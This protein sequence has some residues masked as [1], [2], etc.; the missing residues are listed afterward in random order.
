MR[1][2][3]KISSLNDIAP[4]FGLEIEKRLT[5]RVIKIKPMKRLAGNV[6]AQEQANLQIKEDNNKYASLS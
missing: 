3:E 6:N 5:D 1:N 4:E 2:Q